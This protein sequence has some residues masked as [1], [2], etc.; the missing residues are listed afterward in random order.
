MLVHINRIAI[1]DYFKDFDL[2]LAWSVHRGT[3]NGVKRI[4]NGQ[5]INSTVYAYMV[6][7]PSNSYVVGNELDSAGKCKVS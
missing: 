7:W 1:V 5:P 3:L 6:T 2:G 4:P